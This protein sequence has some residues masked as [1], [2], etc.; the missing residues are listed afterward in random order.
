[1]QPA[2]VPVEVLIV[3]YVE[4]PSPAKLVVEIQATARKNSPDPKTRPPSVWKA[5]AIALIDPMVM[6]A[7]STLSRQCRGLWK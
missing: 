4:R 2:R 5:R 3:D 1:M 6:P 7:I